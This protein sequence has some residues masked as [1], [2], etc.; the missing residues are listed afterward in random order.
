[1]LFSD[2]IG[3]LG[4]P[5]FRRA[6]S[7]VAPPDQ[8]GEVLAG[9][10]SIEVLC[11][12]TAGVVYNG[13]YELTADVFPGAFAAL[14]ACSMLASAVVVS[15]Y[16]PP[17]DIQSRTQPSGQCNFAGQEPVGGEVGEATHKVACDQWAPEVEKTMIY[18]KVESGT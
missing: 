11:S 5:L 9:F 13:V 7:R 6:M 2:G 17:Q 4:A 12:L 10:L 14:A 1:M 18:A 3:G 16:Q 8:Q 15:C